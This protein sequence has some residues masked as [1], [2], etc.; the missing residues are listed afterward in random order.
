MRCE[1]HPARM[2][3]IMLLINTLAEVEESTVANSFFG[4]NREVVRMVVERNSF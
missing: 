4:G 3:S 2:V 1:R